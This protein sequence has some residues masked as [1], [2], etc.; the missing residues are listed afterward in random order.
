MPANKED[1]RE[2]CKLATEVNQP[3]RENS[4]LNYRSDTKVRSRQ[5]KKPGKN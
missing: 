2:F 4:I 3:K 5:I 1:N